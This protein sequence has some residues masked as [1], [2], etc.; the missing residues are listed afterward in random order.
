[1]VNQPA[2][3]IVAPPAVSNPFE[4]PVSAER[5]R[6]RGGLAAVVLGIP[7]PLEML[8]LIACREVVV[9]GRVI[10]A[11]N[12]FTSNLVKE[13]K[14]DKIIVYE[15]LLAMINHGLTM[16]HHFWAEAISKEGCRNSVGL[17]LEVGSATVSLNVMGIVFMGFGLQQM[18]E[19]LPC[20]HDSWW[21]RRR[22][23]L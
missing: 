11:R 1:M 16:I 15:P 5:V 20:H 2:G 6:K 10:S 21:F 9:F 4:P 7:E 12:G 19:T 8:K 23:S 13:P 22:I 18:Q 14:M 17:P 3:M